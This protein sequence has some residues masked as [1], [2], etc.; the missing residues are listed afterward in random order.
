MTAGN[1][2]YE[3]WAGAEHRPRDPAAAGGAGEGSG[4][5]IARGPKRARIG[6]GRLIAKDG[7]VFSF[8][9]AQFYGSIDSINAAS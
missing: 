5:G 6:A 9:D 8:G 2:R 3:S 7:G 1:R 4:L